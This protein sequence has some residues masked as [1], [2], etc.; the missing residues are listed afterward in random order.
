MK[1]GFVSEWGDLDN[2]NTRSGVPYYIAK[3]MRTLGHEVVP[4]IPQKGNRTFIGKAKGRILSFIFNSLFRK[5]FGFYMPN[6][7]KE[8]LLSYSMQVKKVIKDLNLDILFCPGT[9]PVAYLDTNIPLVIWVD[10]TFENYINYYPGYYN[11][12]FFSANDGHKAEKLALDKSSLIVYTSKWAS[13]SAVNYYNC[14][15]SKVKI[16]PRGANL[17]IFPDEDSLKNIIQSRSQET[18]NILFIGA[19]WK[20]KGGEVVLATCILLQQRGFNFKLHVIGNA[21][22]MI[23]GEFPWLIKYGR[24][25]K[26]DPDEYKIFNDVFINGHILFMPTR[27]EAFGI[28]YA[29]ASAF[30]VY[31]IATDTGGVS[32]AI[33]NGV[34][35][36]LFYKDTNPKKY[37][38][39]IMSFFVNKIEMDKKSFE[40]YYYYKT[41]FDW[42]TNVKELFNYCNELGI[43]KN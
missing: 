27:S 13:D 42:N 5:Y 12:N 41:N 29:E 36:N 4:I 11:L 6:R 33:K 43:A 23:E 24:L 25:K 30:G 39:F 16:I 8:F 14:N 3:A 15:P 7:S 21:S 37:A 10:A 9:L 22:N 1:I 38:D 2:P 28:I 32:S 34:N 31:S 19:D 17:N 40:A 26:S 35:G 20:R 18:C